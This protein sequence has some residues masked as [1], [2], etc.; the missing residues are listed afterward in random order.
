MDLLIIKAKPNPSGKDRGAGAF[1][2]AA[3]LA[4]E[5]VDF[6]NTTQGSLD[7]SGVQLYHWAYVNGKG[8]WQIAM[9]FNG[10]L[11]SKEI[12]RVHSGGKISLEQMYYEDRIGAHYHLFTGKNYIWN[13]DKKDYPG[14]WYE[15]KEQWLDKTEYDAY[16]IEGKIL[17][18]YNDKLI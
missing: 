17:Q 12:V 4:A 5:W 3:Q 8:E 16:P 18:R 14:L 6:Q 1:T 2:P 15:P 11:K 9:D 10:I 13:N 7:L